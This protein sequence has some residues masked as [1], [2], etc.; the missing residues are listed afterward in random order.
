MSVAEIKAELPK[1]TPTERAEVEALLQQ[2]KQPMPVPVSALTAYM[3]CMRDFTV[4]KPGWDEDEP[5]EIWEALRDDPS[6]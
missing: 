3:G 1:L 6:A 2:L 4:L 5:L